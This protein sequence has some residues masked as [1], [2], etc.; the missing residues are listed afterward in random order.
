MDACDVDD[1]YE[2]Q[3]ED[4]VHVDVGGDASRKRKRGQNMN[5]AQLR[6]FGGFRKSIIIRA[7]FMGI[8]QGVVCSGMFIVDQLLIL[9]LFLHF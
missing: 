7:H 9:L 6:I 5:M 1:I 8:R 3:E 2:V 4:N